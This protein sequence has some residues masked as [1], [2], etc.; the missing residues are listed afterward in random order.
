MTSVSEKKL[1]PLRLKDIQ[2]GRLEERKAVIAWL[3]E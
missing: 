1:S 2:A 3:Q